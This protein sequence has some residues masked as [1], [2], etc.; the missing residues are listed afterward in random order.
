MSERASLEFWNLKNPPSPYHVQALIESILGF[1]TL[2]RVKGSVLISTRWKWRGHVSS[3]YE[4]SY[5]SLMRRF[6]GGFGFNSEIGDL[7][8]SII[9]ES[10]SLSQT[11]LFLKKLLGC[12]GLNASNGIIIAKEKGVYGI[13]R[14][15]RPGVKAPTLIE[16]FIREELDVSEIINC[17]FEEKNHVSIKKREDPYWDSLSRGANGFSSIT[18]RVHT[19]SQLPYTHSIK[20]GPF[21]LKVGLAEVECFIS[22]VSLSGNFFAAPPS[23]PFT[24]VSSLL[25]MPIDNR[26]SEVIAVRVESYGELLGIRSQ[27]FTEAFGKIFKDTSCM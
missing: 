6:T 16:L 22:N 21:S 13:T 4:E 15:G 10:D 18:W 5:R 19:L 1:A 3:F 8:V 20:H 24:S 2:G 26:L 7:Y 25:G 11:E 17:L 27:D 9:N 14:L 12:V 23:E